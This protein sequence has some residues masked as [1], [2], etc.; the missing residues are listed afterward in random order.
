MDD[1]EGGLPAGKAREVQNAK[2]KQADLQ[3]QLQELIRDMEAGTQIVDQFK[4]SE[5][6]TLM[7]CGKK[8][9]LQA[10]APDTV[11][12]D[13]RCNGNIVMVNRLSKLSA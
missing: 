13:I 10:F 7:K 9:S 1:G 5:Q 11:F 3:H 12:A 8:F 4:V 2:Q 6:K